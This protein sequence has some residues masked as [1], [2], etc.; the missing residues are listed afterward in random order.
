[1]AR[2]SVRRIDQVAGC[3]AAGGTKKR[4]QTR[5]ACHWRNDR[6]GFHTAPAFSADGLIE[7]LHARRSLK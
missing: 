4:Y 1:M 7:Q 3:S 2:L 5:V 6:H